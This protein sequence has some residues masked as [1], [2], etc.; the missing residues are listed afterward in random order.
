MSQ[1]PLAD[2]ES[3]ADEATRLEYASGMVREYCGWHIFPTITEVITMDTYGGPVLILPTLHLTGL[4]V[5]YTDPVAVAP[6]ALSWSQ[7]GLVALDSGCWPTGLSTVTASMTHGYPIVPDAVR[8][9][10]VAMAR[11][12]PAQMANVTLETVGGVTRQYDTAAAG[13]FTN[14]ETVILDRYKLRARP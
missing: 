5:T 13:S 3:L 4:V 2:S 8:A 10:T 1:P 11:R 7:Q 12:M 14:L 6:G 9:V